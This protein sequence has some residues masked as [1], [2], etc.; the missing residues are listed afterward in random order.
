M[1]VRIIK[2][3]ICR[4]DKKGLS[5]W[6]TR[7]FFDSSQG[8]SIRRHVKNTWKYLAVEVNIIRFNCVT[9]TQVF[10]LFARS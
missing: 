8:R 9:V 2:I 3:W 7:N 5:V 4:L 6:F 1:T 10:M